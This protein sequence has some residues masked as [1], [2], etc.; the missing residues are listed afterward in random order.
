MTS[1]FSVRTTPRFD[2]LLKRLSK[3]HPMLV[4]TFGRALTILKVD[5][6]NRE[7]AHDI[8]KL[9][10]V[11]PGDGQYRLRL[12]QWRFRYDIWGS[13]VELSYCG[14]RREETYRR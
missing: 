6:H 14:L 11:Q 4:S 3:Q 1:S 10:G 8:K 13:E 12:G 9:Q 2:R 5:P 7:R